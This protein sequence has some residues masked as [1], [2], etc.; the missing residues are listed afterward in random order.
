MMTRAEGIYAASGFGSL[1][2][3]QAT[4]PHGSMREELEEGSSGNPIGSGSIEINAVKRE[5]LHIHSG[6]W[7]NAGSVLFT[8]GRI[9]SAEL[10][11]TDNFD[12]DAG[13]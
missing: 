5:A 3:F 8:I 1:S 2:A 10:Q 6:G 9:V 12:A 7:L 4:T 13:M 11:H